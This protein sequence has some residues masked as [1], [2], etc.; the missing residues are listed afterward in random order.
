VL[1]STKSIRQL[2]L[3]TD[4]ADNYVNIWYERHGLKPY[5]AL[6]MVGYARP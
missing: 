1:A 2:F 4:A 6:G 5:E 3:T